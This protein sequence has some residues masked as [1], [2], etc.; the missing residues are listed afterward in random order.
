MGLRSD[1]YFNAAK[2]RIQEAHFLHTNGYYGIAMYLSGVAVECMLRAFR[3]LNDPT[4][5]E[6]HDLW[7]LWKSTE[8]ANVHSKLYLETIQAM[9][10]V[11]VKLWN[12]DKLKEKVK[13]SLLEFFTERELQFEE[14]PDGRVS[15]FIISPKFVEMDE[16]ARQKKIW[17]LLR[18]KLKEA[19]RTKVIGFIT[20]TPREYKAYTSYRALS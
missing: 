10:S 17:E 16:L 3:L 14:N 19:E 1:F 7:L 4:F 20:F 15:G 2:D 5:D 11:V 12:M 6:R 18:K 13:G 8:L 9:L